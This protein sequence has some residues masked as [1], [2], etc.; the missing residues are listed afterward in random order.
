M[1]R[2]LSLAFV[3]LI[4]GLPLT[5]IAAPLVFYP[6]PP[7]ILVTLFF[8]PFLYAVFFVLTAGL[9]SRP[10]RK[11]I[12]PGK[13]PR[14]LS[15]P[16]Y[17]GRR[18]YGLCWTCVYYLKPVYFICLSIP[19]LKWLTFRLFGYRGQMNFTVYPDT[20]IR[21]L[22][23]LDFGE[24]AYLANRSTIGTN[25]PS[26]DGTILVDGISIGKGAMVGHLVMIA[27]GSKLGD[28]AEVGHGAACGARVTVA[29]NA[30]VKPAAVVD[31][32]SSI[33]ENSEIG[34]R[35]YVGLAAHVGAHLKVPAGAIVPR[36]ARLA[37]QADVDR[38]C[39]CNTTKS[40]ELRGE[41]RKSADLN[42][43]V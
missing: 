32:M 12:V 1:F 37:L 4:F 3:V 8:A 5:L 31:H 2:V 21:D 28:A 11:W 25:M 23:L 7:V 38:C 16:L 29:A 26:K 15:T 33:A 30:V 40:N 18:L 34:T 19:A 24:G 10:F 35:A 42:G 22:P 9:L 17:R 27:A 14:D 39:S 20:W 6:S 13:F 41:A 43:Q 36:R